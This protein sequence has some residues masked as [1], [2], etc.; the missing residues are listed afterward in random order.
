MAQVGPPVSWARCAIG[1]DLSGQV[2]TCPDSRCSGFGL[3]AHLPRDPGV[4]A[5]VGWPGRSMVGDDGASAAWL[6]VQHAGTDPVFQ[7]AGDPPPEQLAGIVSFVRTL[8]IMDRFRCAE[9]RVQACEARRTPGPPGRIRVTSC[10][11]RAE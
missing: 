4:I 9:Y 11:R 3:D 2:R 5:E 8:R 6:P 7:P 10:G 1:P